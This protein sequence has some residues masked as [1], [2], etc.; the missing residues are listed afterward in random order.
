[1][2]CMMKVSFPHPHPVAVLDEGLVQTALFMP[3]GDA[4]ISLSVNQRLNTFCRKGCPGRET[5]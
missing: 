3:D 1:M 5:H 2:A 4:Y